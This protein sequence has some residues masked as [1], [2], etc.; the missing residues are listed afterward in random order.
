MIVRWGLGE[1]DGVLR[2][3]GIDRALLVTSE[4][5]RDLDL[6]VAERFLGVR[7][8]APVGTVQAA[9]E[10]AEGADGLVAL[11]GGSA[12]DTGKA[13]SAARNLELVSVPT[14]YA[15]AEWTPFYG[16]RDEERQLKTGGGGALLSGIVYE[17]R[18]TVGLPRAETG[19][20]AM[21]ALAHC[22]EALYVDGHNDE[23]DRHALAGA[24]LIGRWLPQV[25]DALDDLEPRTG[26]LEGAAEAGAALGASG[27]ALGHAMAQA[28]GGR[29]GLPHGALNAICLAPA[30]RFNQPYAA[31]AIRRFGEALGTDDPAGRVE[32][33][34]R[35]GRL[36]SAARARRARGRA[37]RGGSRDVAR[38]GARANPQA[39]VGGRGRG[40][41]PRGLV[42]SCRGRALVAHAPSCGVR[43][44]SRS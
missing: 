1:L 17:P 40:A 30:L 11:G 3:A 34:A 26:L 15:G 13:V 19:G 8:H 24:A 16:M 7:S 6:P 32:E 20:T 41:A 2:E 28:L 35:A 12:I 42:S 25:L 39:G 4:R 44:P 37:R 31:D 27:L 14:T 43:L 21:N 23:G 36:R 9:A 10:A 38:P 22:A 29:Y 18:L 5:W 33:L